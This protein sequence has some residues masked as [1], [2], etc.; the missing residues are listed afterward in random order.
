MANDFASDSSCKALWRFE[1]GALLEDSKSS[2]D[3]T[4]G[5]NEP[6]SNTTSYKE[7]SGSVE[8]SYVSSGNQSYLTKSSVTSDFPLQTGD[9]TKKITVACWFY[10]DATQGW[11]LS[12]G[13]LLEKYS[14][15]SNI[16]LRLGFNG[17]FDEIY[18]RFRRSGPATQ[19]ITTSGAN[20]QKE[21][22]YH[23]A[24]S[25]DG[26]AGLTY[27][28]RLYDSV[29]DSVQDFSGSLTGEFLV[30]DGKI[31][32]GRYLTGILD[33]FAVLSDTKTATEIDYIRTG[34]YPPTVL[35][36]PDSVI[37]V[38]SPKL[39]EDVIQVFSENIIL[40][41]P[42]V[43]AVDSS[44]HA[45][46]SESVTFMTIYRFT[47]EQED[48]S[49][50][51]LPTL[52]SSGRFGFRMNLDK[53]LPGISLSA[54][55]GLRTKLNLYLPTLESSGTM[56][57]GNSLSL[58][59]R[60]P[61]LQ[62]S[63]RFA[64]RVS[65]KLPTLSTVKYTDALD[66]ICDVNGLEIVSA[67]NLQ[68]C[69]F[70]TG[71]RMIAGN[72]LSLNKKL[73]EVSATGQFGAR[74]NSSLPSLQ[75]QAEMSGETLMSLSKKLPSLQAQGQFGLRLSQKLPVI[76]LESS[77][78]SGNV[79]SLNKKL[80]EVSA[81]GQFGARLK[82]ST[83]PHLEC[84]AEMSGEALMSLSKKLPTVEAQGRFGLRLNSKLPSVSL[85]ATATTGNVL[86]LTKNLPA[87]SGVGVFGARLNKTLPVL[88]IS[89]EMSGEGLFSF[90]AKLPVLDG[91]GRFGLRLEKKLP[92]VE[93]TASASS[94]A[95]MSLDKKL[96]TLSAT[97]TFGF[98]SQSLKLPGITVS[99]T[100]TG[101]NVMSLAKKLPATDGEGRF[102]LRTETLKL[103]TLS[104]SATSTS[105][106]MSLSKTL[107][108]L[109]LSAGFETAGNLSLDRN[110][111]PL[112]GAGTI[113]AHGTMSLNGKLPAIRI[114]ADILSG[115]VMSLDGI[116]PALEVDIDF[117]YG[118]MMVLD[119]K[120]PPLISGY[121]L[122]AVSKMSKGSRY[123]GYVLR[124]IR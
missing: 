35:S 105:Q 119:G 50:P 22:W 83:L 122:G 88:E 73:P 102:G 63:G 47:T 25:V 29:A 107:P 51:L 2:N 118:S 101:G 64:A 93:L 6:V 37:E 41:T 28:L 94:G 68:I 91:D 77:V 80:P 79:L 117:L 87:V 7:G 43:L 81:T 46:A 33:E 106:S 4:Y 92:A 12:S 21:R 3:L 44:Y 19:T 111:P 114:S 39:W 98:R 110:I 49:H 72:V 97:G 32:I 123:D 75:G 109:T 42:H 104:V 95:V 90:S 116:L 8:T 36:I 69:G 115:G 66:E 89:S 16:A 26:G 45:L 85:E 18:I 34:T 1:P 100:M 54:R 71:T 112:Q 52:S 96:G 15:S 56:L 17:T 30:G 74:L 9:A 57:V 31:E 13:H 20:I 14:D 108:G 27:L 84:T 53:T 67:D 76:F 65:G 113:I 23:V 86:S 48:G 24:L 5:V 99:A 55:F 61:S 120:L 60:L 82:D 78:T 38:Y 70:H 40:E 10:L 11:S 103:P 121:V 59:K 124:H 58:S 62:S